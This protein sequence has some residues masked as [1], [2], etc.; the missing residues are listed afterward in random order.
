MACGRFARVYAALTRRAERALLAHPG[1]DAQP[2]REGYIL[3]RCCCPLFLLY[4]SFSIIV[5]LLL[6]F[7]TLLLKPIIYYILP[8]VSL[9]TSQKSMK[10]KYEIERRSDFR[11]ARV[12]KKIYILYATATHAHLHKTC[13]RPSASRRAAAWLESTTYVRPTPRHLPRR[14][15]PPIHGRAFCAPPGISNL[16]SMAFAGRAVM[17]CARW[18]PLAAGLRQSGVPPTTVQGQS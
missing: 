15:R 17:A 12:R 8:E 1:P 13:K 10:L 14:P 7:I 11:D 9:S 4:S 5:R 16:Y 6:F 2:A 18:R 3:A